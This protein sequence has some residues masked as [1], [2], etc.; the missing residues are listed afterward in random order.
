MLWPTRSPDATQMLP[1]SML[2]LSM[3]FPRIHAG[4]IRVYLGYLYNR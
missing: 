1:L 2:P 3:P 4:D